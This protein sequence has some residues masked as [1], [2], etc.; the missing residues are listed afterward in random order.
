MPMQRYLFIIVS[1]ESYEQ[2]VEVARE[3][4]GWTAGSSTEIR[5]ISTK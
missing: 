5:E 1:A 3:M 2:A 4:P